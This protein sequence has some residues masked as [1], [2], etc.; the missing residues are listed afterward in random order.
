MKIYLMARACLMTGCMLAI[1]CAP[2][3]SI[4]GYEDEVLLPSNLGGDAGVGDIELLRGG[5]TGGTSLTP[6]TCV[7]NST[8]IWFGDSGFVQLS[9]DCFDECR[10]WNGGT[11]GPTNSSRY[12]RSRGAVRYSYRRWSETFSEC[13]VSTDPTWWTQQNRTSG[14][15]QNEQCPVIGSTVFESGVPIGGF[16][17]CG[18]TR[19]NPDVYQGISSFD[20]FAR[21]Y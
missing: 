2:E 18:R 9:G 6:S 4:D 11:L 20:F 19:Y 3:V 12:Q 15:T 1:G 10:S 7:Q 5:S 13:W 21:P 8:V 16:D 14:Q 17:V